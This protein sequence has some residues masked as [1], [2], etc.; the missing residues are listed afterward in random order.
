MWLIGFPLRGQSGFI[1]GPTVA[2]GPGLTGHIAPEPQLSRGWTSAVGL[3]RR[4]VRGPT[5][6][7]VPR[8]APVSHATRFFLGLVTLFSHPECSYLLCVRSCQSV[9]GQDTGHPSS[10]RALCS[11]RSWREF[12]V[13]LCQR[14]ME[15]SVDL[16]VLTLPVLHHCM[17]QA[18]QGKDPWMQP[19]D[20][21]A[22]LEGISFSEFRE[23]MLDW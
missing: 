13:N 9:G 11:L 18:P 19:E 23:R 4:P 17:A 10:L 22:A 14:C 2:R 15:A 20:T 8:A 12:L 6:R 1:C 3:H 5:L 21:W 16:W 7:R